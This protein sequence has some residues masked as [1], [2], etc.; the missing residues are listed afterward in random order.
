MKCRSSCKQF[1]WF[2]EEDCNEDCQNFYPRGYHAYL[3]GMFQEADDGTVCVGYVEYCNETHG[4]FT[5][6]ENPVDKTR[7]ALQMIKKFHNKHARSCTYR[8]K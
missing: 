3:H 7:S 6:P 2:R 4:V 8:L 1:P 5:S